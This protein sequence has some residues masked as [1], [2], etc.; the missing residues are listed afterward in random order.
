ME[1]EGATTD[2]SITHESDK[3]NFQWAPIFRELGH[4]NFGWQRHRLIYH[5]LGSLRNHFLVSTFL[6]KRDRDPFLWYPQAASAS[7]SGSGKARYFF[8]PANGPRAQ[9]FIPAG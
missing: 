9:L 1:Q 2:E 5:K 4:C 7:N 6:D 3:G 8:Q